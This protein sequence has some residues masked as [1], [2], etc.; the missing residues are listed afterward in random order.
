MTIHVPCLYRDG[1]VHSLVSWTWG[2]VFL[3]SLAALGTGSLSLTPGASARVH[4]HAPARAHLLGV[5]GSKTVPRAPWTGAPNC[6]AMKQE[7][8][9]VHAH[10]V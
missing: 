5:A 6:P 3:A 1:H 4:K 7:V 10:E 8:A 2:V 9:G